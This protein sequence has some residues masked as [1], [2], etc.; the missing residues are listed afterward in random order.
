VS[1]DLRFWALTPRAASDTRPRAA[2]TTR[3][4]FGAG[5]AFH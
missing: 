5:I 4:V 1:L 2:A 3:M